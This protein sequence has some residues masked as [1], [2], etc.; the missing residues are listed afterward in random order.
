MRSILLGTTALAA[1][2]FLGGSQSRTFVD[3]ASPGTTVA[4]LLATCPDVDGSGAVRAPDI[5]K[6]VLAFGQDATGP[7]YHFIYDLDANGVQRVTDINK[8][9]AS[10]GAGPDPVTCPLVDVQVAKATQWAIM[11]VP[12][13]QDTAALNAIGYF[14]AGPDVPGQGVH[15]VKGTPGTF[16][17]AAPPRGLVYQDGKLAAQLYVVDGA[18]IGWTGEDD[19]TLAGSCTDGIDND[20]DG[21]TDAAD[22]NCYVPPSPSGSA[23]DDVNIDGF[24]TPSPCSWSG[25]EGWHLHYNLCTY[26]IGTPYVAFTLTPDDAAC[27]AANAG[28]CGCGSYFY[29]PRVG[30]MGHLWNHLPNANQVPDGAGTNGRFADCFP[31]TQGWKAYNCPQ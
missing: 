30:W 17:P 10:F 5:T 31:D 27:A 24:C 1:L 14:Q 11:N 15:W 22:T 4:P 18:N 9:I 26:H 19:L 8:V 7:N 29:S 6:E 3:A 12:M 2:L 16:D 21:D 23:P 25:A 13:T 20:D 28:G